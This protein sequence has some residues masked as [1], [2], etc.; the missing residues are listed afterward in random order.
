M[1]S[2]GVHPRCGK[3]NGFLDALRVGPTCSSAFQ[4]QRV[5]ELRFSATVGEEPEVEVALL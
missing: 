1:L 3:L 4:I 5:L 2:N